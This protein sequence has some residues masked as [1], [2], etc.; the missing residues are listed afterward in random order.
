MFSVDVLCIKN[1]CF[2]LS[3]A[4]A[5]CVTQ[6]ACYIAYVLIY[7]E[8]VNMRTISMFTY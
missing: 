8:Y 5:K 7:S 6:L 2:F 3:N 1:V 4:G